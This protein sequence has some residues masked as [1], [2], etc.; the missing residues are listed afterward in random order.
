MRLIDAYM[1][2]RLRENILYP[3]DTFDGTH[4]STTPGV[5]GDTIDSRYVLLK[6]VYNSQV[7][8]K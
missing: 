8:Y 1:F 6:G 3:L 4:A 2:K 7:I 5:W